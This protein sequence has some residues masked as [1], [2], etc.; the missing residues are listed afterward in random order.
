MLSHLLHRF[1]YD[2]IKWN[3]QVGFCMFVI[4]MVLLVCAIT[5][6][7]SQP[8]SVPRRWTWIAVVLLL[9]GLG[10]LAYL[11]VAFRNRNYAEW[12]ILRSG[13]KRSKA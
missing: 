7:A 12:F 2:A 6:I 11:P 5:S 1:S 13:L 8:W 10:L 4:W 3:W 9:P